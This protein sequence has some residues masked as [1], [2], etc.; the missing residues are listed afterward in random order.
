M[1]RCPAALA[2]LAE[3]LRCPHCGDP[4]TVDETGAV[5]A[6]RHRFDLARQGYL[7]LLRVPAGTVSDTVDMVAARARFLGAGHYQPLADALIDALTDALTDALAG[8]PGDAGSGNLG[9]VPAGTSPLLLEPGAGT[10]WYLSR[11]LDA[12]PAA[13]GLAS[14]LSVP[15]IRRAARAHPHLAA[16]VADTWAGLPMADHVVDAVLTV[17]APRN[18]DEF[19]RVLR[20]GGVLV[21]VVPGADHLAELRAELGLLDVPAGKRE[22]LLDEAAARFTHIATRP[23]Q[24][25]LDLDPAAVR[26]LVAMGPNAFHSREI[27]V[28]QGRRVR[29][30]ADVLVLRRNLQQ[31]AQSAN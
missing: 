31:E 26:D 12:L 29:L 2:R 17:F 10:G 27:T 4:L 24:A 14:D 9:D 25:M 19:A 6:R 22:R 18:L 3:V 28:S 16:V 23:V 21:V 13:R 1:S 11:V 15:A 5:C 20:P 8:V 7:N 30:S